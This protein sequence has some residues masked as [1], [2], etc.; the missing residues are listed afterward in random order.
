MY[1]SVFVSLSVSVSVSVHVYRCLKD[2][3]VGA[4]FIIEELS[5]R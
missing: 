1:E 5:N 2:D 4:H 3:G